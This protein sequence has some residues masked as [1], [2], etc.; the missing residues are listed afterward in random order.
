MVTL[1]T[2][3]QQSWVRMKVGKFVH[4]STHVGG[5]REQNHHAI[6]VQILSNSHARQKWNEKKAF[7]R[8]KKKMELEWDELQAQMQQM[9]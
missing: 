3:G 5:P 6:N 7:D 1:S 2:F 9:E 4:H 8:V